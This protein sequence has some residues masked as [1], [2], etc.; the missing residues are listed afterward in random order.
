MINLHKTDYTL[1]YAGTSYT[2]STHA[3]YVYKLKNCMN[4]SGIIIGLGIEY[5]LQAC[6]II[7]YFA[8]AN[9]L[10]QSWLQSEKYSSKFIHGTAKYLM[11]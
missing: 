6:Y 9:K 10:S 7:Y 1:L 8:F 11:K 4:D 3:A 2:H 5:T